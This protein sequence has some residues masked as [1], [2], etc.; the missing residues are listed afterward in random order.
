MLRG[1]GA[2]LGRAG[3]R[4]PWCL[5]EVGVRVAGAV[6]TKAPRRGPPHSL[7]HVSLTFNFSVR[8]AL[9]FWRRACVQN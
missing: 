1:L 2:A 8:K 4:L 6:A 9:A 7:G 3:S 5:E